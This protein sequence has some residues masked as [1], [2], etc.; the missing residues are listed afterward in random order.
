MTNSATT[1]DPARSSG[2]DG[3][4]ARYEANRLLVLDAL[5]DLYYE[6]NLSPSSLQISQRAGLSPRSLFRYFD[7]LEDLVRS[8]VKREFERIGTELEWSTPS[9]TLSERARVVS[10]WRARLF[11]TTGW[12]GVVARINEHSNRQMAAELSEGRLKTRQIIEDAFAVEFSDLDPS[13]HMHLLAAI[14][15]ATSFEAYRLLRYDIGLTRSSAVAIMATTIRSI[16][17]KKENF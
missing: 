7:D 5:L 2:L 11:D 15:T 12:V 4:H 6:G 8:A 17:E 13:T 10:E 9:G 1:D 3:R 16:L 14:D